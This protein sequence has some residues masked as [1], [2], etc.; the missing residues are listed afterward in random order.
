[1]RIFLDAS[2]MCE[3][4]EETL[5][6]QLSAAQ[7]EIAELKSLLA[8]CRLVALTEALAIA[9]NHAAQPECP[10][11]ASYICDDIRDLIEAEGRKE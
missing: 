10:E 7:A 9:R 3:T 2:D 4:E 6:A 11:R 8:E 5:R 1:M